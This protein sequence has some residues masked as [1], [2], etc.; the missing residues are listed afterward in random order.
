MLEVIKDTEAIVI[1]DHIRNMV[2]EIV[3]II[4]EVVIMIIIIEVAEEEVIIITIDMI[5]IKTEM[6]IDNLLGIKIETRT[7]VIISI[8]I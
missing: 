3:E 2:M 6:I 8:K 5:I 7:A 1:K 4:I